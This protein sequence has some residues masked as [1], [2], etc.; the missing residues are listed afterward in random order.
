M[1]VLKKLKTW[2]RRFKTVSAFNQHATWISEIFCTW[3]DFAKLMFVCVHV[4]V[5]VCAFTHMRVSVCF[6]LSQDLAFKPCI[7]LWTWTHRDI[8][9]S[10]PRVLRWKACNTTSSKGCFSPLTR[11]MTVC[12]D[13]GDGGTDMR[14]AHGMWCQVL[15]CLVLTVTVFLS[16]SCVLFIFWGLM[17]F[18]KRGKG[19]LEM[20]RRSDHNSSQSKALSGFVIL[21]PLG[22]LCVGNLCPYFLMVESDIHPSFP[23]CLC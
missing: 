19:T 6:I 14:E 11:E 18:T 21:Y 16:V 7:A 22:R 2:A 9:A 15:C 3:I 10:A 1:S 12:S 20:D 5:C 13:V 17:F 4:D 8:P 23:C